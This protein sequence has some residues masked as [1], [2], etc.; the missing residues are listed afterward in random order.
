MILAFIVLGFAIIII[1]WLLQRLHIDL[2]GGEVLVGIA[3]A[4]LSPTLLQG[5]WFS[6]VAEIGLIVLMFEIGL[7]IDI[8]RLK[9]N[10]NAS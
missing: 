4:F 7:D 3:T 5:D 10:L 8:Q 1:P 2:R 6:T 9:N